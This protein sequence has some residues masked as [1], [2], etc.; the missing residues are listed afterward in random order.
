[1]YEGTGSRGRRSK[2]RNE[3]RW[4]TL[5]PLDVIRSDRGIRTQ[6]PSDDAL[7]PEL[8][9]QHG[10]SRASLRGAFADDWDGATLIWFFQALVQLQQAG[11]NVVVICARF[12]R[13]WGFDWNV[14]WKFGV[15]VFCCELM[16]FPRPRID[17]RRAFFA[18]GGFSFETIRLV[19]TR[20]VPPFPLCGPLQDICVPHGVKV[21][22]VHFQLR[23][24][25]LR[26][27]AE[28]RDGDAIASQIIV[29][30]GVQRLVQISYEM[31]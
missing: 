7:R 5:N 19:L 1:M 10:E 24:S 21:R 20:L 2:G 18:S 9:E 23:I 25:W 28:E 17:V 6:M 4:M 11:G 31:N 8:V 3:T 14:R 30:H 22:S 29:R 26:L 13:L 27:F 12:N 16:A 15:D